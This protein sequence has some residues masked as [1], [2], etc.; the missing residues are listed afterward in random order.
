MDPKIVD[1]FSEL[2]LGRQPAR[3]FPAACPSLGRLR[4]ISKFRKNLRV[5]A[6]RVTHLVRFSTQAE[7]AQSLIKPCFFGW[8]FLSQCGGD[9]FVKRA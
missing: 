8:Y 9:K 4:G 5:R 6:P 3:L 2:K 1:P 7:L